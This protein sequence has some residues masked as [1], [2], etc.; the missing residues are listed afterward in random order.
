[1][2]DVIAGSRA[3][4]APEQG[5]GDAFVLRSAEGGGVDLHCVDCGFRYGPPERDPRVAAVMSERPITDLSVLNDVGM[6]DRLIA[7]QY[8]CPSCGLLFAVNVQQKGDPI[9]LEWSIDSR[10]LPDA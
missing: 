3:G 1:M 9:M 5:I 7:R 4:G 2:S 8:F 10:T 6:V